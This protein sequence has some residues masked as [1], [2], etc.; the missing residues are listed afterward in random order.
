MNAAS[1]TLE[2]AEFNASPC[3]KLYAFEPL[4]PSKS[5]PPSKVITRTVS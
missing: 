5:C 1:F 3:K 4:S 2:I